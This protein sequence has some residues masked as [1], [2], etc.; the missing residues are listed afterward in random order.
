MTHMPMVTRWFIK[1]ALLYFVAALLLGVA[2]AAPRA[3]GLPAAVTVLGPVYFHLFM[4]GWVTQLIFGVVYWMFP[5]YSKDHPRGSET[6]ALAT[7][8]LLNAG[9][10]LRAVAEPMH[11]LHPLAVWGWLVAA[12]AV[13]QWLAG[14]AF[15]LNT[16]SRVKEK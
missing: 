16:W 11:G 2:L 15:A 14:M 4:L 3:L 13:L 5:R 10:L 8:G 6:L 9:L 7:F 12:A 1:S